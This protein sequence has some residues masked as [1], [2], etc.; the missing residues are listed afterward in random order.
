MRVGG[1]SPR[2][3]CGGISTAYAILLAVA[4]CVRTYARSHVLDAHTI[5][6]QTEAPDAIWP[7]RAL[8]VAIADPAEARTGGFGINPG[9]RAGTGLYRI[10]EFVPNGYVLIDAVGSTWRGSACI[11]ALEM[12][13][14]APLALEQ[15]LQNGE[16]RIVSSP[17][18][19]G[20]A[21]GG[22][23][24]VA[25]TYAPRTRS[26]MFCPT[27]ELAKTTTGIA[28]LRIPA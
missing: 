19:G 11:Q 7:R 4:P 2:R 12:R 23:S 3:P 25:A 27:S 22:A 21:V 10:E 17:L 13:P 28:Q 9:P 16:V 6:F 24:V 5:R 20:Q 26:V 1:R 18:Q 8:E 14:Y 15:A